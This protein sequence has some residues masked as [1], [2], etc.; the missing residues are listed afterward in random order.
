MHPKTSAACSSTTMHAMGERVRRTAS[1][2]RCWAKACS[3]RTA[4]GGA[5]SVGR[6]LPPSR[7]RP[8][9][10]SPE[11]P[12]LGEHCAGDDFEGASGWAEEA[13]IS[14]RSPRTAAFSLH[15][16]IIWQAEFPK[17]EFGVLH[18]VR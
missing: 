13:G 5:G 11:R 8:C 9:P 2:A 18:L 12:W 3:F 15:L 14:F 6:L 16:D 17:G 7:Q 1:S 10:P 4:R